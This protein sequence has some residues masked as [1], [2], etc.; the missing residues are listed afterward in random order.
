MV[1]YQQSHSIG[2]R[3]TEGGIQSDIIC[4]RCK[5][6]ESATHTFFHCSFAQEVW[7]LIP[8]K[9][10]VH[11]ATCMDFKEM[12]AACRQA[13]CLPPTGISGNIILWMCWAIWS[14]RN[15]LI[16]ENRSSTPLETASKAIRLAREWANT[17]NQNQMIKPL[18][19]HGEK[20]HESNQSEWS[21]SMQNRHS[22][23]QSSTEG[24]NGLDLHRS[25]MFPSQSRISDT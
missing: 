25:I 20:S 21:D 19:M 8:L 23:Q 4:T 13:V 10:V 11:L 9:E 14:S 6:I 24:Q 17:Q 1:Y 7:K 12:V 2:K 22:F 18:P 16:F 15:M 3:P 5:G